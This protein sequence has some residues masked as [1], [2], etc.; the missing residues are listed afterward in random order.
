MQ[1]TRRPGFGGPQ[2][3]SVPRQHQ[4]LY[5]QQQHHHHHAVSGPPLPQVDPTDAR[6]KEGCQALEAKKVN[7][8]NTITTNIPYCCRN[9][10]IIFSFQGCF[11]PLTAGAAAGACRQWCWRGGLPLAPSVAPVITYVAR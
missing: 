6:S 11:L 8:S 4:G 5:E 7:S 2:R 3:H 9:V 10:E 1:S